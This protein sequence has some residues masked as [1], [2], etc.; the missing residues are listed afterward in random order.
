MSGTLLK[1][2]ILKKSPFDSIFVS[3][4]YRTLLG[5]LNKK[6]ETKT[7]CYL[8]D[9]VFVFSIVIVICFFPLLWFPFIVDRGKLCYTYN[10]DDFFCLSFDE[11]N[12]SIDHLA[13]NKL[14]WTLS[15]LVQT[16]LRIEK[17]W[18]QLGK[19]FI[20]LSGRR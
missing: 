10:L 7:V 9:F 5:F 13:T 1:F 17:C 14:S 2:F 3:V 4:F 20:K 12:H 19:V 11:C 6:I 15:C 8:A 18:T 16:E